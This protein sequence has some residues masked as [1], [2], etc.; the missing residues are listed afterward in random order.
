[1]SKSKVGINIKELEYVKYKSGK[2]D[3]TL[4]LLFEGPDIDHVIVNTLRRVV[5]AHIPVYAYDPNFINFESNSSVFN[6][7]YMKIHVSNLPIFIKNPPNTIDL[8]EKI[9]KNTMTE[10]DEENLQDLTMYLDVKN[11]GSDFVNITTDM[12]SFYSDGAKIDTVYKTPLF[13]CKIKRGEEIKF[14]TRAK[15]GIGLKSAIWSATSICVFE[16]LN[17]HKFTFTMESVGQVDEYDIM[18]RACQ[19]IINK[20]TRFKEQLVKRKFEDKNK[21]TLI[22][23]NENHTMGNLINHGLQNHPNIEYSGY[24]MAHL[25]IQ[26]VTI[27]LISNGGKTLNEILNESLTY[28]IALFTKINSLLKK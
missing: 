20:L 4:K 14:S 16:E 27:N 23:K 1:M 8:L 11:S 13:I 17:E 6:N 18:H 25:L 10:Q 21:S 24:K 15:L 22:L 12:C 9:E 5:L 19:V 3:N 2:H 28:Q 26:E 7:D